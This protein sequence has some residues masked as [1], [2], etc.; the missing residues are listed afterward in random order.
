MAEAQEEYTDKS[1]GVSSEA[2][3]VALYI[4][5]VVVFFSMAYLTSQSCLADYLSS[6]TGV[7]QEQDD[8]VAKKSCSVFK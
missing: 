6:Q 3:R 2:R 7:L 8:T 5:G 4:L 1:G